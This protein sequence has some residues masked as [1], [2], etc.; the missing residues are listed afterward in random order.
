MWNRAE[1][2]L[3][4]ADADRVR[5]VLFL[6]GLPPDEIEDAVQEIELRA[7]QHPPRGTARGAWAC[8]VATNLALDRH[9][10]ASRSERA[11]AWPEPPP[12]GGSAE[13]VA[14][15]DAVR[16]GLQG[17]DDSLR[18]AVVLR[19]YADFAVSEIA[20]AMDVP[21]GTVKSRLHRAVAEL[22]AALPAESLR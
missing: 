12:S 11:G 3:S 21:E 16:R 9:R 2:F 18:A 8:A 13:E 10:R 1:P 6:N 22:R 4:R 7:L 14:L 15:R 5:R 17:L 20:A 19:F